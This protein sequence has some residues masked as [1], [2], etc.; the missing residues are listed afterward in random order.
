MYAT[1]K[2]LKKAGKLTGKQIDK[3]LALGWI[4]Q[5]QAKGLICGD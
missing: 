3:A 2:R 5:E 4:T 1:L